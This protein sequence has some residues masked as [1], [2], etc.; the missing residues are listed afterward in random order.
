[1]T[2]GFSFVDPIYFDMFHFREHRTRLETSSNDIDSDVPKSLKILTYNIY[3]WR[4]KDQNNNFDDLVSLL[5]NVNADII[6][7]Q[8]VYLEEECHLARLAKALKMNY[9]FGDACIP[10]FGNAILSKFKMKSWNNTHLKSGSCEIRAILTVDL[11]NFTVCVT[12]LD[13]ANETHRMRQ[14]K[15]VFEVTEMLGPHILIGDFN[16][17]RRNDYRDEMWEGIVQNRRLANWESPQLDVIKAV[18]ERYIDCWSAVDSENIKSTCSY[19]T[20]IDYIFISDANTFKVLKCQRIDDDRTSDH[21]AV[22]GE[23]EY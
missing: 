6:G 15:T 3:G 13:H 5:S 17:L 1:V 14:L 23:L 22:M 19:G 8:E 7:L 4:R 12:H 2:C 11:W 16:S 18:E 9:V 21:F 10:T 20:R